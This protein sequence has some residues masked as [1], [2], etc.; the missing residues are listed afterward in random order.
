[1]TDL[2]FAT[3]RHQKLYMSHLQPLTSSRDMEMVS[4]AT[5]RILKA[6]AEDPHW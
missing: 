4:Y 1:M 6:L 5:K 3:G 2:V